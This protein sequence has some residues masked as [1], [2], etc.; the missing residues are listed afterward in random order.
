MIRQADV[1]APENLFPFSSTA[2]PD[3]VPDVELLRKDM[4]MQSIPMEYLRCS[5]EENCLSDSANYIR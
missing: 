1:Y 4:K 3:I 2:L 5:L